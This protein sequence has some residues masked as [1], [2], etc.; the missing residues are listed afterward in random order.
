MPEQPSQRSQTRNIGCNLCQGAPVASRTH[1]VLFNG[2]QRR[3]HPHAGTEQPGPVPPAKSSALWRVLVWMCLVL[4]IEVA[5]G[6]A[7]QLVAANTIVPASA[8]VL[9][10]AMDTPPSQGTCPALNRHVHRA[11][12]VDELHDL[13]DQLCPATADHPQTGN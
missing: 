13:Q 4:V 8:E 3:Q 12:T 1:V 5:V 9:A 7:L 2:V 10:P 6:H 11:L